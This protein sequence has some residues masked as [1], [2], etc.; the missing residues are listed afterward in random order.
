LDLNQVLESHWNQ[1][2]QAGYLQV[3]RQP[4]LSAHEYARQRRITEAVEERLAYL[5]RLE[6]TYNF[7]TPAQSSSVVLSL[8][9]GVDF[10]LE[11]QADHLLA[12]GRRGANRASDT[13]DWLTKE[14]LTL[15][16]QKEVYNSNGI[17]D[18]RLVCGIYRRAFNPTLG[19]R[20]TK[21]TKTSED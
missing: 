13:R 10:S 7:P 5:Q 6:E 2:Q 20:P 18:G 11:E 17:P 19:C 16:R 21:A 14:Q 3:K 4:R 15:R 9:N 8:R 12:D 1:W